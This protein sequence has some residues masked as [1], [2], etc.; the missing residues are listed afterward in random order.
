M[1]IVYSLFVHMLSTVHC[2]FGL[3]QIVHAYTPCVVSISISENQ[4]VICRVISDIV[5]NISKKVL[6]S[7]KI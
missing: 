3:K 6:I 7:C 2:A 5:C 4:K 1:E